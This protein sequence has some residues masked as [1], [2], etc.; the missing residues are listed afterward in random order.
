MSVIDINDIDKDELLY[1]LWNNSTIIFKNMSFNLITAK[2][3]MKENYPDYVCG[4]SIKLDIY[5]SN[6]I[7][8]FLY[9][10]DNGNNKVSQIVQDIKD[11]IKNKKNN[12]TK[13]KN[14]LAKSSQTN[15]GKEE[16]IL[17]EAFELYNSIF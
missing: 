16:E 14:I 1:E 13:F 5:N 8:P 9:D 7:D 10:R 15:S 11:N 4:R 17:K 2:K 12:F 3:E 6:L